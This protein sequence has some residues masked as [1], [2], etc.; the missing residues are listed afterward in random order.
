MG[1]TRDSI[2]KRRATGGKL[3]H[4]RKKRKYDMGRQAANTK[5]GSKRIHPVRVRGGNFK[6]RALRLES[7]NFSWGTESVTKK[8]RILDV[9]YNASN[10]ELVRTKT[11]VKGA[12]IQ[13]DSTP[14]R[15]W[16]EQHYGVH[17]GKA[18][19]AEAGAATTAAAAAVRGKAGEK[20]VAERNKTRK[21]EAGLEDQFSTGR[22]LVAI[23]SRP[24]Q[25]GRADGYVLEDKELEFYQRKI[26]QKK[27][28]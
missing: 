21:L 23:S 15:T 18:K 3:K 24:G 9:L 13:I 1:I 8:A 6:Y 10:N 16:Y 11:L 22:L 14:F 20:N 2:H 5:M 19:K 27:K 12:I 26:Q 17:L 25:S 7:G 28:H 4:W